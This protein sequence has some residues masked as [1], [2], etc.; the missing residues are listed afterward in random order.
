MSRYFILFC[1]F[2]FGCSKNVNNN[3]IEELKTNNSFSLEMIDSLNI[4]TPKS[5][6][7]EYSDGYIFSD[8]L[9]YGIGFNNKIEIFNLK[10][11]KHK[12][13]ISLD[14]NFIRSDIQNIIVKN[15]D[16]ILVFNSYPPK[17]FLL[18]NLGNIIKEYNFGNLLLNI[19][20]SDLPENEVLYNIP[21]Y[22]GYI[23]PCFHKNKLYIPIAPIGAEEM[24]GFTKSERIGIYDFI[25]E[26]WEK[27]IVPPKGILSKLNTEYYNYD[28]MHTY[29]T[30]ANDKIFVNYPINDY[31]FIYNLSGKFID[32]VNT[33]SKIISEMPPPLN[34]KELFD[35]QK[36]WNFRITTPFYGPL[37]YHPKSEVFTR[38][39]YEK[40]PLKTNNNKLNNG[41]GRSASLIVFDKNFTHKKE[42]IFRNAT[43]GV[44]KNY[45]LRNGI[46]IGRQ[47]N[48]WT[49]ENQ[50][51]HKYIYKIK[52]N[53]N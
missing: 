7:T 20:R 48:H 22:Y 21:K 47:Q 53:E 24:S 36:S 26:K 49:N 15:Q 10:T 46:I 19:K 23:K 40:Q 1:V 28:L 37:F 12:K 38:V 51:I 6:P 4:I 27:A 32:S 29:F 35:R 52:S 3:K 45:P 2:I 33:K 43:L 39:A 14:R 25:N 9:F 8:S 5:V 31:S 16:S 41:F 34:Q 50:F 30:I 17:M 42:F 13:T 44:G 18:N 11:Q